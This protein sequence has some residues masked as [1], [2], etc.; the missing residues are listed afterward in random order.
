M[1]INILAT[2][3]SPPPRKV[4][5]SVEDED[6]RALLYQLLEAFLRLNDSPSDEQMHSLASALGMDSEALEST[7]YSLFADVLDHSS[8]DTKDSITFDDSDFDD[9][10]VLED[11]DV[12]EVD[13]GTELI[14]FQVEGSDPDGKAAENDGTPDL[15]QLGQP[16]AYKEASE[17]NGAPDEE[18]LDELLDDE[19]T[20]V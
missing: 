17:L 4:L 7:I 15:E 8:D 13:D 16:D 3:S 1:P 9:N 6:S 10:D 20:N 19:V 14:H 5:A 18:L 12:T 11:P 2:T